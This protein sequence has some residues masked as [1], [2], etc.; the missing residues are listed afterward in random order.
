MKDPFEEQLEQ[1]RR[2]GLLRQLRQVSSDDGLAL[3]IS[4]NDLVNWGSNDYLGFS[5]HPALVEAASGAL[6]QHGVGSGASRLLTGTSPLHSALE[7]AIAAFKGKPA[8]LTFSSGYATAVG[9]LGALLGKEDVVILDKLSHACLID[10]AR[11][12]QATV[13]VFPHNH[14]GRLESLLRWAVHDQ[15]ARR[16]VVVTESVFSMDGDRAPLAEIAAL[17][18]T[19]PFLLLVDEAHAVGVIGRYGHGLVREAKLTDQVDLIMGT[20]SKALG[21]SGGY[22]AAG[23]SVIALLVN[24]ARSFIYSTAPPPALAA[25]ALASLRLL[26]SEEGEA[27]RRSLWAGINAVQ[28]LAPARF[29][30]ES[31]GQSAIFPVILGPTRTAMAAAKFM[32]ARGCYAPAV[33]YPT[34]PKDRA[35]LRLTVTA[36]HTKDQLDRLIA[37]LQALDAALTRQEERAASS[38]TL[39]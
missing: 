38:E 15:N 13:R 36:A 19:Y 16:V 28:Q 6:L 3:N 11:M 1:L 22:I 31:W 5:R 2:K 17:K 14:V 35:R 34:V 10:G 8:A 30:A 18:E 20:L 29:R 9:T 26:Q 4:R 12:S 21:V 25:A 37:A 33:R 27:A 32:N 39:T 23:E 24:R 7:G